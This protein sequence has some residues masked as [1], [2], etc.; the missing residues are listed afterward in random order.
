M[1]KELQSTQDAI[2]E[3]MNRPLRLQSPKQPIRDQEYGCY[4]PFD[5]SFEAINEFAHHPGVGYEDLQNAL[6]GIASA[7]EKEKSGV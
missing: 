4:T 6:L 5:N 3:I 7:W 2:T 1:K